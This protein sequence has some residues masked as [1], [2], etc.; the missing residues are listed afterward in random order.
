[1]A[2]PGT[3][4]VTV[5]DP[6]ALRAVATVPQSR[7]ALLQMH[8]PVRI[9]LPDLP[10]PDR[11]QTASSVTVLPLADP[12]SDSVKIR[13]ALP[14]S[15]SGAVRPGMFARAHF[16][17]GEPH[18]RL[19]VPLSAVV[20]RTEV[21]AVYVVAGNGSASLRQVRLGETS[22]DQVEVLAG[23][24]PGERIELDPLAAAKR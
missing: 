7:V 13:L 16:P 19:M 23:L 4:L 11:W 12:Q 10:G 1:M 24:S 17:I 21:D 20:H 2:M 14:P 8:S 9:E 22:A 5:L 18:P 6:N 15:T 3:P